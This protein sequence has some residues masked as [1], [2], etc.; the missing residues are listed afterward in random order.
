MSRRRINADTGSGAVVVAF[1]VF[2]LAS[3]FA[4]PPSSFTNAVVGPRALPLVIGVAMAV[5]G[6]ALAARGL[7][8]AP[9]DRATGAPAKEEEAPQQSPVRLAVA[10]GLLLIYIFLFIPLGYVIS[11]F[12]FILGVT[13]YF[14]RGHPV[15][16]VV[17]ALIFSLTV[18]LLFTRLLGVALPQGPLGF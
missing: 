10:A 11:T 4:I 9:A 15:R 12:L 17:Y 7:L 8:R 14:D 6:A 16:N 1:A 3:A 13:M 2:Y 5:A 18:Y